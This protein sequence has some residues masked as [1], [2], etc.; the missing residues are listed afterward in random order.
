V[1]LPAVFV[2]AAI[3]GH[4]LITRRFQMERTTTDQK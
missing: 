4:I 2:L 1:W 3:A